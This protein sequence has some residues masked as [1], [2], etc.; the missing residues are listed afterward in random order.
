V[1]A[2]DN[3]IDNYVE[4]HRREQLIVGLALGVVYEGEVVYLHGYGLQDRE[5]GIPVSATDTKFRWA[6]VS[7]PITAVAA[8]TLVQEGLLDLDRDIRDYYSSY[9]LPHEYMTAGGGTAA[10]PSDTLITLRMI[11]GHLS[12]IQHYSNGTVNPT[13]KVSLRNNPDINTGFVWPLDLWMGAPLL[14]PPGERYSYTTMGFNLAGAVIG[15]VYNNEYGLDLAPDQ[16]FRDLVS[17]RISTKHAPGLQPDYHWEDIGDR[18]KGYKITSSGTVVEDSDTDVSW[19]LPGGGYI[20]TVSDMAGFCRALMTDNPLDQESK[21][22]LF[23]RQKLS[24]GTSTSYGLGFFVSSRGD[25]I[26]HSGSQEKARSHLVFYP[27]DELCI[28][29]VANTQGY[30]GKYLVSPKKLTEGVEDIIRQ[31]LAD[32]DPVIITR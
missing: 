9:N 31:R 27:D 16:S 4:T 32:G 18:A 10:L 24:D 29:V 12:G 13:P 8:M 11:L 2:V 21:N 14:F 17:H 20:S 30:S 19:K 22:T 7:K 3:E 28:V 1:N 25:K 26:S 5:L 23:T 6:S 15:A